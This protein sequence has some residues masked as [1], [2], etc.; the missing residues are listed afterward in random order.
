MSW[1]KTEKYFLGLDLGQQ[2]DYTAISI[3]ERLPDREGAE[4]HY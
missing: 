3:L 4:Y 1:G 2:S